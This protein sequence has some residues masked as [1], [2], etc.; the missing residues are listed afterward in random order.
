MIACAVLYYRIGIIE[1]GKGWLLEWGWLST[2]GAQAG[3]FL[4]FKTGKNGV[5]P[6]FNT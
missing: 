6:N 2:V 1:Y 3:I 5:K 4:I